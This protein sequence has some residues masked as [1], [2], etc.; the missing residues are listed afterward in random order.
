MSRAAWAVLAAALLL[1]YAVYTATYRP[2]AA[3]SRAPGLW[4]AAGTIAVAGEAL[5]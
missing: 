5:R 1:S 3:A 4:T 2:A